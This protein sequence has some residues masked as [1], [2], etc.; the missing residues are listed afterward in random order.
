MNGNNGILKTK[1]ASLV[2][3]ILSGQRDGRHA[4]DGHDHHLE[5][6]GGDHVVHEAAESDT[7]KG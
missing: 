6:L 7:S 5:V 4:N 3:G 1:G 2:Y